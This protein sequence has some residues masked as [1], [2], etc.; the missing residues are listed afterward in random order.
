MKELGDTLDKLMDDFLSGRPST[1]QRAQDRIIEL[2]WDN[3]V[4]IIRCL[5]GKSAHGQEEDG[6]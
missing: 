1:K 6:K 4:K 2:M 3:K 5:Q